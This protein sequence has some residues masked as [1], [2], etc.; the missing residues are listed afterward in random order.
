M[1]SMIYLAVGRLEIEWGK[2]FGFKDHS[3]LFQGESDVS[4]VPYYYVGEEEEHATDG[5]TRYA[6]IVELK[7]GLSK[8]LA[9]VIQ[10]LNL[11]GHTY[12]QC[13][14]EFSYLASFN[15]FDS[16]RFTFEHLCDA[17]GT[18]DVNTISADYGEGGEDSGK[19]FRRELSPRLGLKSHLEGDPLEH[20]AVS[21][22]MENLS[23]YTVL[24]LLARN[25]R[26]S[27]LPVQW[28]FNDIEQGGYAGR[29]TFV[30]PLDP[31]RRFLIVTEGSSD[32]AI[33]R[34]AWKILRPNVA[35]FF[36]FV[37]MEE[38]YP[39]SGTGNVYRFVQG[40]ISISV[41][42]QV[43]VLFDNDAEGV[44]NYERCRGLKVLPNMRILKLPDLP[45]FRRFKAIG[46]G[47]EYEAD[48]NGRGAAIECYLDLDDEA[49]VRWTSYSS[50]QDTY[51]GELEGKTRYMRDFLG[52]RSRQSS[53]DYSKIE[54][55]LDAITD[56][57]IAMREPKVAKEWEHD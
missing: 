5:E 34:H 6:P 35:D 17:L 11:L 40:L 8:P 31:E 4:N 22:A 23:A 49:R 24:H 36:D 42:N 13:E 18:V 33:L 16:T 50:K 56:S 51:Q 27:E 20:R 44:A 26:A 52:Q 30:R 45:A 37:D 21:E 48:I 54:A 53:Y 12:A 46:P 43:L 14:R 55:V 57:A 38:G 3:A 29:E 47:G 25:G 32:A 2:N 28:A 1:G 41:Q 19:F 10:R 15:V 9:Q 39:F 7:E